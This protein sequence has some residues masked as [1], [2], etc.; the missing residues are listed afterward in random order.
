MSTTRARNPLTIPST[1][2]RA[3]AAACIGNAV[4]WYDFAIYGALATVVGFYFFPAADLATA[5]SAAFASM[6]QPSSSG[7]WVRSA[8][9][10]WMTPVDAAAY[11]SP[12]SFR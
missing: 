9:V 10:G 6:E 1:S 7:H 5:L 4:E 2:S 11:S 3:L 12:S 8:S